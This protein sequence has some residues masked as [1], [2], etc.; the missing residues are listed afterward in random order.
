MI[1]QNKSERKVFLY[2]ILLIKH[3]ITKTKRVGMATEANIPNP[4]DTVVK[5]ADPR[6]G[7]PR[8][9]ALLGPWLLN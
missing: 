6:L 5:G 9:G 7:P 1:L 3:V 4:D 8:V 2:F